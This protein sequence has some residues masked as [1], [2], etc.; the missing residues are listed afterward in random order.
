M[1]RAK[2]LA[3]FLLLALAA[4]GCSTE[5]PREPGPKLSPDEREWRRQPFPLPP[6]YMERRSGSGERWIMATPLYWQVTGNDKERYHLLPFFSFRTDRAA[7]SS[8]GQALNYVWK[9]DTEGV[10]QTLFPVYW[11]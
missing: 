1:K 6:F 5:T 9:S 10:F 8:W 4:C 7:G 3:S 2:F 11:R